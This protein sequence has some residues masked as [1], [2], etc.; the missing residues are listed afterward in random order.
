M[1]LFPVTSEEVIYV[2]LLHTFTGDSNLI[3]TEDFSAASSL[4][5]IPIRVYSIPG[6]SFK[7]GE[8]GTNLKYLNEV[9]FTNLDSINDTSI[10]TVKTSE[11]FFEKM[12]D[13]VQNYTTTNLKT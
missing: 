9:K 6:L 13:R 2:S 12:R 8:G 10:W 3:L 5:V 4:E 11:D 7:A 1:S